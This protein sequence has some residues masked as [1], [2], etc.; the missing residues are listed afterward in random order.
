MNRLD[1]P[2]GIAATVCVFG[3]FVLVVCD[4]GGYSCFQ[5][6]PAPSVKDEPDLRL[7]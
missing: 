6:T 7:L 2:E 5:Q 3:G 4:V 1:L